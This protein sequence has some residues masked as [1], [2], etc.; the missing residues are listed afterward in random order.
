MY[1]FRLFTFIFFCMLSFSP[2]AVEKPL[3]EQITEVKAMIEQEQ[4]VNSE[5]K[6]ELATKETEISELKLKLKEIEDMIASLKQK[7]NLG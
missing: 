4:V 6:A 7:H 2:Q 3:V 1:K 5:L